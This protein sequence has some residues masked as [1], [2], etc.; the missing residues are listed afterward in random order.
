MQQRLLRVLE[1]GELLRLGERK[2]RKIDV[3]IVAATNADLKKSV[4]R[5]LFRQDLYYRLRVM[6]LELP[7][8][9]DRMEDLPMLAEHFLRNLAS[10]FGK[11]IEGFGKPALAALQAHTWP[12]NVRELENAVEHAAILCVTPTVELE[13]LPG[14]LREKAVVAGAVPAAPP[15]LEE[16]ERQHILNT[17]RDCGGHRGRTADILGINRRTLYRKLLDYGVARE[18]PDE[19]EGDDSPQPEAGGTGRNVPTS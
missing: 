7:P 6:S 14:E 8:L 19:E 4:E 18:Q 15:T 17:L 12:G 3:R 13:D 10:R 9:R 1:T 11:K 16:L 5:G 2:V